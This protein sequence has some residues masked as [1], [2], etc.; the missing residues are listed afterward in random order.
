MARRTT[1][2][3]GKLLPFPGAIHGS[4]VTDLELLL[5]VGLGDNRALRDLFFRHG[6]RVYRLL[7]SDRGFEPGAAA[8][9]AR[10]AFLGLGRSSRRFDQ[11]CT[12]AGWI[13]REALRVPVSVDVPDRDAGR[14]QSIDR[15]PVVVTALEARVAALP[16][17]PRLATV[18]VEREAMSDTEVADALGIREKAVWRLVS[19][20]RSRLTLRARERSF[21]AGLARVGRC[22]RRGRLC[23]P[24]WKLNRAVS[25]A[26]EPGVGW[27]V[28]S[29]VDCAYDFATLSGTSAMLAA[30]PRHE[31]AETLRD[32]VAVALLT[33]PLRRG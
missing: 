5:A 17:G 29:C 12:V 27:H 4:H 21:A 10:D 3:S 22:L 30:L 20:G 11:K 32:E 6:D 8:H 26:T 31:M 13:I 14:P 33:A 16:W 9:G 15:T 2:G 28:S 25:V 1:G 24:L 19:R 18:L 23:P 7:R